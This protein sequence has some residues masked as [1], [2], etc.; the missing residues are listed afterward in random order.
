M[1]K[2]APLPKKDSIQEKIAMIMNPMEMTITKDHV[3]VLIEIVP[4]SQAID[5]FP[6]ME[7]YAH[8]KYLNEHCTEMQDELLAKDASGGEEVL[9]NSAVKRYLKHCAKVDKGLLTPAPEVAVS[10]G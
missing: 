5:Y 6:P 4:K 3:K 9:G 1:R 7:S 10:S 8:Y 2:N